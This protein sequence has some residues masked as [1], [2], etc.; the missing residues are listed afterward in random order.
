MGFK[1]LITP[2]G[3][4]K[5]DK[6][7]LDMLKQQGYQLIINPYGRQMTKD[8]MI[9]MVKDVD[10]IIIGTDPLGKDVMECSSNLKVISKYG[11]GTDN[12]D[13]KYAKDKNIIVTR[14]IGA[15][16]DAVADT[17]FALMMAVSKKIVVI[18]SDCRKGLWNETETFEINKKTL[19]LIGLGFIG[20]GVAKRASG[21]EMKVLAYDII[22][23]EEYAAKNN[24]EYVSLERLLRE[25]DFISIHVPLLPETKY[26]IG[27]KEIKM[28]KPRAVI[29]NTA[30]GGIIDEDALI[31]A[32]REN[33]ILGAGL[34]VF[35]V[36]PFNSSLWYDIPNV[37][38]SSHC[39]ADTYESTHKMSMMSA[40]NV[41]DNL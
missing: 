36:E 37:V 38:L 39:A 6:K 9:E 33:R 17:A 4:A 32:L 16:S 31:I 1:V 30:R 40:Q 18:D 19:G 35:E 25:S 24:I 26:M 2:P 22:K 13:L 8:E 29:V 5:N 10:A 11:V 15:N 28:M 41:I 21:F 3:F 7:P 34:D 14:T 23:D 27:A 12:I 20:K